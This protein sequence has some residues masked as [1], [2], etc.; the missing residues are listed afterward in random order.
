MSILA[1]DNI[2]TSD[3]MGTDRISSLLQQRYGT[4]QELSGSLPE[5]KVIETLLNHRSVR[6]YLPQSVPAPAVELAISAAQSAPSSSNLQAWSVVAI[7]DKDRKARINAV[8]GNQKQIEQA[9]LLLVWLADLARLRGITDA[10]G[11]P[12]EGLEYL[13]SFLLAIIDATL[14]A[15]NAVVA[16][17]SLGLGTC[18]IGALRNNPMAVA[19][20]LALP[21]EVFPVFGLTVGYPDPAIRTDVKPRLPRSRVFHREQY[22]ANPDSGDFSAYNKV[23]RAFQKIQLMPAI[24]WTEQMSRRIG[25]KEALKNRDALSGVVKALGFQI[26]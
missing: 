12:A 9:P 3:E 16:F 17:E 8:A 7:E 21:K 15:Q 13:E 24:D 23:L 25:T 14:A 19:K 2:N 18:Y 6:F 11:S 5:T 4:Q 22:E 20:E 1:S 10:Q 26:K